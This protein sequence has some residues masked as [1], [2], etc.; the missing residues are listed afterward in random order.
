MVPRQQWRAKVVSEALKEIRVEATE[1][2]GVTNDEVP[3]ETKV[4]QSDRP[5]T[6]VGLINKESAQDWSDRPAILVRPIGGVSV[7]TGAEVLASSQSCPKARTPSD[8]EEDMLDYEP[9][10]VQ[11]DMDVNV[12]YLS[13][14]NYSL[15][16]DDEVAEMSFDPRDTVFQRSKD[17]ENHLKP[18]Y[19]WGHLDVMPI[20]RM[21]IDGGAIINL[22]SYSFF[23]K[24]SKSDEELIKTNLMINDV[25]GGDP[26]GAKGVA[27]MELTIGSKTLSTAFFIAE[28]QGNY[29]VILGRDCIHANR[30]IPST[31]HQFLIQWVGDNIEVVHA[32]TSACVA[33]ADSSIWTHE[34]VK[35]LSCLVLSDN[36][37]V[38]VSKDG[39]VPIHVKPIKNRLNHTC[40][41]MT[42]NVEWLQKRVEHY[43]ANKNDMCEAI[44]ETEDLDR[45]GPAFMLADPLEEIDIGDDVTHRP[46]FVNKN[47]NVD[48]KNNLVELLREYV[49]CFAWN[50]PEMPS[51]SRDL[52]EHRLLIKVSFRPF[53]QHARHY[54]P[55]MYDRIKEEIDRLLKANF[56]RPCS[57]TEWISNI[58]LVVKKGSGKIRVCIDFRNLNRATP[59]DEYPMPIANMLI[60]HA[61]GHK[62]LSFLDGNAGYNQIFIA[63]EDMYKMAFRCPGFVGLFE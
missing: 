39:F 26:I 54:N 12:I 38:S 45:L 49:D 9:S 50:Y 25:G 46:T 44:E 40:C 24:M 29:S 61:S 58:V 41:Y 2:R 21:L 47:L 7:Q 55:L 16:G 53:K 23:K 51:L 33:M 6:L 60:N 36:N 59:K 27:P 31:L 43:R 19:I 37:F 30:C 32:N 34:D 63:E 20:S 52:V 42:S 1:E 8:D 4:N 57:Y 5:A 13:S 22:M 62:V 14:V 15:I 17:S 11:E 10:P 48:Y 3:V 28:V 35:C 18:L 56:I